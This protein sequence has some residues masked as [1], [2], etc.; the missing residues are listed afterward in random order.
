MEHIK[1]LMHLIYAKKRKLTVISAAAIAVYIICMVGIFPYSSSWETVS[2]ELTIVHN[3]VA[4]EEPDWN[5]TGQ[6]MAGRSEPGMS[7]PKNPRGVNNGNTDLYIRLTMTVKTEDFVSENDSYEQAFS[8]PDRRLNLILHA[9][10]LS[11]GTTPLF[12]MD[13]SSENISKWTIK[14]TGC[15]NTRFVLEEDSSQETENQRVFYFYYKEE[16]SDNMCVV[17]T[18]ESD[19]KTADLFN[20]VKIPIY[21]REYLGVFDQKYSITVQAEGVPVTDTQPLTVR[22]AK[23]KFN[24]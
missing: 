8:D 14:D 20:Y 22:Q 13:T 3:S 1:K 11:D 19:K 5:H 4:I 6:E 7:I 16:N 21:K 18:G 15:N 9:L 10:T 12:N 17:G 24:S 2:N 23:D